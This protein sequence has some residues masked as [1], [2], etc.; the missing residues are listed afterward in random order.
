MLGLRLGTPAGLVQEGPEVGVGPHLD[1]QGAEPRHRPGQLD[2]LAV[3]GL[4]LVR[5]AGLAEQD[6]QPVVGRC[7]EV[8]VRGQVGGAVHHR[9][10]Q[11]LGATQG[12]RGLLGS[13]G[14]DQQLAQLAVA[15]GQVLRGRRRRTRSR[16]AHDGR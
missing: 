10:G 13:A 15:G 9:P 11:L 12:L 5:A 2:G 14:V 7:Q 8:A 16:R 1:L 6:A 4:R 3:G